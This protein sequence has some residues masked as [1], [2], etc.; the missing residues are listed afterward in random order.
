MSYKRPE[1]VL[2]VI[3]T[4]S[5]EVLL[6]E[7]CQPEGFWQS[8]TGSLAWN[9]TAE[10]AALREVHEETGLDVADVLVD[11]GRQNRFPILPAWRS[12]YAP[13]VENNLEHVFSARLPARR[14]VTLN[15]GEHRQAAWL[16]LEQARQKASSSTNRA[17]IGRLD[18][19]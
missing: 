17:A 7:R 19:I 1:S 6:L 11:C 5:G 8:V 14:P 10:A 9:E 13:D 4:L 16:P 18:P 3:Y 12:R 15:P 2:V